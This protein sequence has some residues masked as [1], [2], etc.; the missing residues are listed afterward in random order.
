ML[1]EKLT[2]D[3]LKI[4]D[5]LRKQY[6]GTD[7][8]FFHGQFVDNKTFLRF[9]ET[10]KAPMIE[11]FGG[12]LIAKER[13]S[14]KV[15][16]DELRDK[17]RE[18]FQLTEFTRFKD[19]LMDYLER[20]NGEDWTKRTLRTEDGVLTSPFEMFYY[21][22][23]RIQEWISNRY[24][25]E[26]FEIK[27]GDG[28]VIKLAHGCKVMRVL[29]RMAKAC[30]EKCAEWFEFLRLRQSQVL[31]EA[32][33]NANL[34]ISIHPLDFITASYNANDWCSCMCWED[35]EYRRG[36][37]E[38]MNSPMV[39][40]AYLE[41]GS[42]VLAWDNDPGMPRLKWNSKKWR[43]FFIVRPDM[44][45]GIKGYP[46]WNRNL[47]DTVINRLAD[48]FAPVFKTKYAPIDD[49]NI[50]RPVI[51]GHNDIDV[52]PHMECGPA[53]Y[54]D[55]DSDRLYHARFA[56]GCHG[57]EYGTYYDFTHHMRF[58]CKKTRIFY[59]GE[60]ECVVCGK[61]NVDFAGEDEVACEDCI[62]GFSCSI[63]HIRIRNSHD[64]HEVNGRCYC[65]YCYERLERCNICNSI[66]GYSGGE[67]SME[68]VISYR[69]EFLKHWYDSEIIENKRMVLCDCGDCTGDYEDKELLVFTVCTSCAD[70]VF[71][72]GIQE[73]SAIHSLYHE[74]Y[75]HY[76]MVP[77]S[78]ITE[79]GIETL[80]IAKD[81]EYFK[82]MHEVKMRI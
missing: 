50:D 52:M 11:A 40:C 28:K 65:P 21:H 35:G 38:M 34:C 70:K 46:Y 43:E 19:A 60:S 6:C 82:A 7:S 53:M 16:E 59:S 81:I 2:A 31:N 56:V 22:L 15:E 1:F 57:D 54:N 9:W 63:C 27:L 45:V 8:G 39:V 47:E 10:A 37:I 42:E 20:E 30:G 49:W 17:M 74:R 68:F 12:R 79:C 25:G 71:K 5:I 78:H 29:G 26:T 76:P 61:A 23:F 62:E 66:C 24:E 77:L 33:I 55:F 73:F 36:V 41:S 80:G 51:D 3:D 32:R 44:I 72:D 67:R 58:P 48:I 4:L 69:D 14:S 75:N 13:I 18:V 64:L